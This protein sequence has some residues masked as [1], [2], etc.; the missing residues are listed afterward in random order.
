M[1]KSK[2]HL[3][4]KIQWENQSIISILNTMEKSKDDLYSKIQW[5]NQRM[6]FI[7]K[8]NGKIKG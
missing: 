5:E 1:G 6:I 2:D 7:L 3:Y 8:Y 4:F